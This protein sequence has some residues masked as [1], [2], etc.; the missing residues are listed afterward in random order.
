MCWT[1]RAFANRLNVVTARSANPV[2]S[3]VRVPVM[4]DFRPSRTISFTRSTTWIRP[5][6][7][8]SA[9]TM[10]TEFDPRS[11]AASRTAAVYR[12]IR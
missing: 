7:V 12:L 9:T 11:I 6:A 4:K 10:W 1:C 5:S 2:V 8:T 3:L